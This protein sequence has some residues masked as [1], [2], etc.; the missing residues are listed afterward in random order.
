MKVFITLFCLVQFALVNHNVP[1]AIFNIHQVSNLVLL[2]ITI[3]KENLSEELDLAP[4]DL[5]KQVILNYLQENTSFSFDNKI[6]ELEIKA[7]NQK[8]DHLKIDCVFKTEISNVKQL[9]IKNTCLLS[10]DNHSNI[11][12]VDLNNISKDYRMYVKR[13][14]ISIDL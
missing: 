13:K 5:T 11:I 2:D 10:I 8:G 14:T 12:Q 1:I 3:D 9:E 6:N 4:T 7:L